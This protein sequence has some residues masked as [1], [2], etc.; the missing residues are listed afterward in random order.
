MERRIQIRQSISL[1]ILLRLHCSQVED[2]DLRDGIAHH[3]NLSDKGVYHVMLTMEL[4]N[5]GNEDAFVKVELMNNN[6][7]PAVGETNPRV[8]A[9]DTEVVYEDWS[10]VGAGLDLRSHV[11]MSMT[12]VT[13]VDGED[14]Y[15]NIN[16]NNGGRGGTAA[17]VT[18][19]PCHSLFLV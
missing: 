15:A 12:F 4:D 6:P 3:F 8:L 7:S 16:A 19:K 1:R 9:S 11:N 5:T 2:P 13:L 18:S 17:V 14:V 10:S